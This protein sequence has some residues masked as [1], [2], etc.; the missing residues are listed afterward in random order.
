MAGQNAEA[1]AFVLGA[2]GNDVGAS[3]D[4]DGGRAW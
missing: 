1:A 4:D 2:H 3:I